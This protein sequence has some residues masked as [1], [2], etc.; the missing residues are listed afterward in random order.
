MSGASAKPDGVQSEDTNLPVQS[1]FL[2]AVLEL[3]PEILQSL[4]E[5]S[6]A[7]ARRPTQRELKRWARRWNIEADWIVEWAA[8]T[9]KWQREGRSRRWDRFH[10]PRWSLRSRWERRP[11][12]IDQMIKRRVG[13]ADFGDWIGEPRTRTMARKRA[14]FAFQ[15]VL[16]ESLQ[17]VGAAAIGAGL[18]EPTRRR[19]RGR[20]NDS[21]APKRPT[22]EVFFWLAGYQTRDWSRRRI[23]DAVDVERNAVG[24]AI[25]KL[26]TELSLR[27]RAEEIYD[28]N[29]TSGDIRVALKKARAGDRAS[30]LL[31]K[32]QSRAPK[33]HRATGD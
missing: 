9:V 16:T 24:M 2:E 19:S 6:N 33:V 13:G 28:K 31:L 12:T 17:E 32:M 20:T 4:R 14:L 3:K 18:F 8:H 22:N 15:R 10:H 29:A 21:R 26:A 1:R 27:L 23:A 11:P 25:R 30:E 7:Q 5:L